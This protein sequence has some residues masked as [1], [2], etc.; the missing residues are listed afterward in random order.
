MSCGERRAAQSCFGTTR[1]AVSSP[2]EDGC[3]LVPQGDGRHPRPAPAAQG[4]VRHRPPGRLLAAVLWRNWVSASCGL[5]TAS[6]SFRAVARSRS[7]SRSAWDCRSLILLRDRIFPAADILVPAAPRAD[8]HGRRTTA[9]RPGALIALAAASSA[10]GPPPGRSPER[11]AC[12]GRGAP[13]SFL[14]DP[15]PSSRLQLPH[16]TCAAPDTGP[17]A[18]YARF[19]GE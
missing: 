7:A 14:I 16:W 5:S 9:R 19:S 12:P 4:V 13:P 3:A 11:G 15:H 2:G 17:P 1:S 8:R 6:R 18:E 10:A